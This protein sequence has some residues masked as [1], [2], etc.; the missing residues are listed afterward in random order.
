MKLIWNQLY[1]QSE[2]VTIAVF[3]L[4]LYNR[5]AD[6]INKILLTPHKQVKLFQG[7]LPMVDR[8]P[9]NTFYSSLKYHYIDL[10]K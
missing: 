4:T 10:N 5:R 8:W 3:Q 2:I 1:I 7:K 6:K 9:Q